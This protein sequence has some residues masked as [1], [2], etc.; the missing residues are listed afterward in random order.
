MFI[1]TYFS[2]R[3]QCLYLL[4]VIRNCPV[5]VTLQYIVIFIKISQQVNILNKIM[6]RA[7]YLL[8]TE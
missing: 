8:T 6:V 3:I 7:D 1:G 4:N 2:S 5:D